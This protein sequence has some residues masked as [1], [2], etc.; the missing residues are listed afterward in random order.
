[1]I[2]NEQSVVTSAHTRN[3]LSPCFR[4]NPF[5]N[6]AQQ[7]NFFAA[8]KIV[9]DPSVIGVLLLCVELSFPAF[10]IVDS[11]PCHKQIYRLPNA[12]YCG[13]GMN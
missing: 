11:R 10:P 12:A 2:D 4:R 5:Q 8:H 9:N 3:G 7:E 6:A 1:M 13:I